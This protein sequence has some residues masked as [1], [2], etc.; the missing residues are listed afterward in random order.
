MKVYDILPEGEENAISTVDLVRLRGFKSAR[1]LQLVIAFERSSGALILSACQN[2]GGYFR[3][4]PGE[5]GRREIAAFEHTLRLRALNTLRVL[6]AARA[7]LG[8][9]DGQTLMVFESSDDTGG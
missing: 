6:Q 2:G 3:P 8:D 1:E 4:S 5:K 7:A 9:I